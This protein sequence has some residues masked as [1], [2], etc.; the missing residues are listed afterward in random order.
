VDEVWDAERAGGAELF[1][2]RLK[3]PDSLLLGLSVN[4]GA[5][6]TLVFDGVADFQLDGQLVLGDE[7]I[8]W[9]VLGTFMLVGSAERVDGRLV[10][11]MELSNAVVCFASHRGFEPDD[12]AGAS[13]R[14]EC[15]AR[16]T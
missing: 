15:P 16:R 5:R 2:L 7:G 12:T 9:D 11:F 4:A 3:A 13:R 14:P 10:Y 8:G 1:L 6:R